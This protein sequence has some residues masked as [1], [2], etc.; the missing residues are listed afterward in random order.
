[1]SL[2]FSS[3]KYGPHLIEAYQEV[4]NTATYVR[5]KNGATTVYING[6]KIY[7]YERGDVVVF[8]GPRYIRYAIRST[9]ECF[10]FLR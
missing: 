7:Q 6:L 5:N 9:E 2:L 1:M 8:A 10:Y 4:A 3:T